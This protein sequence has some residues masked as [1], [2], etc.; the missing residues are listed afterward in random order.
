MSLFALPHDYTERVYAGIL[1]K[2]IGVYL[3]RPFEG[4]TY[5]KIRAELGD[6]MGYVHEKLGVPLIVTDDDLSGTF[7]FVRALEDYAYTPDLTPAQIGQTWL[8]YIIEGR[9]I[10]WWGGMGNSTE[11]TA[12]LRLKR[13]IIAPASGSSRLNS[14]EV[15]EQ[16][17][18]QI[19]IDGWGM[20]SP[21]NPAQAA[22]LAQ[23]AASVS[24]DGEAIY[25]SQVL[26]AMEALA[27][28]EH[29]LHK[30]LDVGVSF[31]P[32]D[33]ITSQMIQDIR[34]WHRE[35][36]D[37]RKTRLLL[38]E[39]YGYHKYG[40][41]CH[42]IPNHALIILA[43]LY[44][45]DQFQKT[46]MIVNTS[47]WDTDC[48]SG[49]VGCLLGI[50][51]GLSGLSS[52]PD[53]RGPLG[54]RLYISSA[55]GGRAITD[56]VNE[57][58]HLVKAAHILTQ[59]PF[60]PPK[61]GA[62]FHFS[63]PGSI[64][65][66]QFEAS[67]TSALTLTN[68]PYPRNM[69]QRCLAVQ[70]NELSANQPVCIATPTF[71]PADAINMPGYSLEASPT[72]Y[73]GQHVQA[74]LLADQ[75]N[76]VPVTCQLFIRV[77]GANDQPKVIPGSKVLLSA[78]EESTITWRIPDTA[79][80]P[81]AAI[82]LQYKAEQ[83]AQGCIYLDFLTWSGAP[84]VTLARPKEKGTMWHRAWVNGVDQFECWW[85]EESYR[86]MQNSGRGLIIQGTREWMDYR[87]K[88][89][90]TPH[91]AQA[92]GL[93]ARVQGMQRYYALVM[94]Q[95]NHVRLIKVLDGE[96]VL[97]ESYLVWVPDR[98]YAIVLQVTGSSIK[99]WIDGQQVFDVQDYTNPLLDGGVALICQEGRM[100][101]DG[102]TIQRIDDV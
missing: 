57:T 84:E 27:F 31:I 19:F 77:Y 62:R 86:L 80:A 96:I 7:T 1:G 43:L 98:H 47:G 94:G 58:Y 17:G 44:G 56:A 45:E 16:I 29:D 92:I 20:L 59:T 95:T 68:V 70:Y 9:T 21:G 100:G 64:Q 52:G 38:A 97:A 50:K 3:G 79:G 5:E 25:A 39:K 88:A 66:F 28:T 37:W 65:G 22:S 93:G 72:L 46:L 63:L 40:G 69:H 32:Q 81:I 54:D 24:H 6:I 78:G 91:M 90:L 8:N 48:N 76:N 99:A 42:I 87:V 36:P 102:V 12:Y 30:L 83:A 60:T 11:H 61:G 71:I 75:E 13:G 51:N 82:G 4:W 101:C 14:K 67:T 55:D 23:R 15:A 73:P 49:N 85:P 89:T 10:L 74:R 35:E 18:A 2:M 41:N 26:A 33:S 53:W 34:A